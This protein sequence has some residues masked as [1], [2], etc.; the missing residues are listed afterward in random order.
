MAK[1]YQ[2]QIPQPCHENWQ[3]MT[4]TEKGRFCGSC[5][6]VV[7]DFT[8]M[9]DEQLLAF[10][11]KKASAGAGEEVC[12]R[13]NKDQLN[14]AI[15]VPR[16]RMP[17]LKYFFRI[18]IP[19]FLL[20][21]DAA[22]Q[23]SVKF[24]PA[25]ETLQIRD[26]TQKPV[27]SLIKKI[28]PIKKITGTVVDDSGMPLSGASIVV[29]ETGAGTLSKPN[30][31]FILVSEKGFTG[32]ELVEISF[33]GYSTQTQPVSFFNNKTNQP[34]E[35][36]LVQMESYLTG[37]VLV[38]VG[39]IVAKPARPAKKTKLVGECSTDSSNSA[40]MA[41]LTVFPNPAAAAGSVSIGTQSLKPGEYRLQLLAMNGQMKLQRS[42]QVSKKQKN[43]LYTLPELLPGTYVINLISE[44]DQSVSSASILIR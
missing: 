20:G 19:A 8:V 10:F 27:D 40:T 15:Q 26:T 2:L 7:T 43:L 36:A 28:N 42:V 9:S 13:M 21:K 44:A 5:Q 35:V 4:P 33:V 38:T 3:Q 22:A 31:E 6:K 16:K 34:S 17:W 11:R 23:G 14:R 29:R 18:V 12:G 24:R 1:N 25:F 37:E 30:G 41:P 39:M 32:A